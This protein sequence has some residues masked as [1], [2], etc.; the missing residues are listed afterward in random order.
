MN[1]PG[2]EAWLN[3]YRRSRI[4]ENVEPCGPLGPL[5]PNSLLSSL[6]W[7][8]VHRMR[9]PMLRPR[10]LPSRFSML[11]RKLGCG[12]GL[13]RSRITGWLEVAIM[14]NCGI[15]LRGSLAEIVRTGV[16]PNVELTTFPA[17]EPWQRRQF[18]Y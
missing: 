1:C 2:R 11:D 14:L 18:S 16:Y 17:L 10:V 4:C 5:P 3:S 15:T 13:R 6:L 8:S 12:K 9:T 7:Q